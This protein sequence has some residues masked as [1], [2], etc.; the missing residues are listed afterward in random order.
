MEG[1]KL[2]KEKWTTTMASETE[3]APTTFGSRAKK[4]EGAH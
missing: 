2:L 4:E 3:K 1:E